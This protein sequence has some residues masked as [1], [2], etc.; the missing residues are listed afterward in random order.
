MELDVYQATHDQYLLGASFDAH[1]ADRFQD[2]QKLA[3]LS[4]IQDCWQE[5]DQIAPLGVC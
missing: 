3:N 5:D 2:D 4:H 1:N